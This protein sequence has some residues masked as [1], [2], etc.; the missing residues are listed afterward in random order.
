MCRENKYFVLFCFVLF[1][2]TSRRWW[3]I[4]GWFRQRDVKWHRHDT[5]LNEEQISFFNNMS[6]L[7]KFVVTAVEI[8]LVTIQ[9]LKF[10]FVFF[11]FCLNTNRSVMNDHQRFKFFGYTFSTRCE[12]ERERERQRPRVHRGTD[13]QEVRLLLE[14]EWMG[15]LPQI[16][17]SQRQLWCL[18][19]QEHKNTTQNKTR[20][21]PK[22]CLKCTEF[23]IFDLLICFIDLILEEAEFSFEFVCAL[24]FRNEGTLE[25][26]LVR[27]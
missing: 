26:I 20:E 17:T 6:I 21:I 13:P 2:W 9:L 8:L 24:H 23:F 11:K 5:H 25:G 16:K 1:E 7:D 14:F 10:A 22:C 12:R 4:C 19:T 15:C 3:M 27:I 18:R